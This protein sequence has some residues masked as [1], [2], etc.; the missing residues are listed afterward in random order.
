[1]YKW[2]AEITYLDNSEADHFYAVNRP[3]ISTGDGLLRIAAWGGEE[4]YPQESIKNIKVREVG[5]QGIMEILDQQDLDLLGERA[6]EFTRSENPDDHVIGHTLT[7]AIRHYKAC[8][9]VKVLDEEAKN[10]SRSQD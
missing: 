1:M 2:I 4:W 3:V 5:E 10:A 8:L 9:S 7:A 6:A